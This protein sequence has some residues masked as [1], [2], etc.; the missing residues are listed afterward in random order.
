MTVSAQHLALAIAG[1]LR[2]AWAPEG[3][4]R[5]DRLP[6]ELDRWVQRLID[7]GVGGLAWWRIRDGELAPDAPRSPRSGRR[8]SITR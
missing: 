1:V 2:R 5:S 6:P 3:S 4:V 8:S 7:G